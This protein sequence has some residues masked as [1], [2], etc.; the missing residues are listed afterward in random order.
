MRSRKIAAVALSLGITVSTASA[1]TLRT[2][3]LGAWNRYV[4]LTENRIHR[5]LDSDTRFLAHEFLDRETAR[6]CS[7]LVRQGQYCILPLETLERNG[8]AIRVPKELIHHWMGSAFI[9]GATLEEVLMWVQDYPTHAKTFEEVE[10]SDTLSRD[11]DRFDIYLRLKRKKILTVHYNTEHAVTYRRHGPHRVSST[12]IATKIAQLESPGEPG[13]RELTLGEDSG[14]LWR[15]NSYWRYQ[16]VDGGVIV[17]C[18][19]VSLSRGIPRAVRWLVGPFVRSVPRES[20]EATLG[21]IRRGSLT[22]I[23]EA[24]RKK[25][26][27]ASPR[28]N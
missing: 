11:G 18:E 16:E 20:L 26:A 2:E 27:V 19:S 8:A 4:E 23:A 21:G 9:P 17:E 24:R 12:S 22:R 14:F 1:A 13:E 6:E 5:E 10:A 7:E 25:P 15:L 3:T 28:T